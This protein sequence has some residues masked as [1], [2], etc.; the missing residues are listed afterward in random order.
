MLV[1]VCGERS[2]AQT[3]LIEVGREREREGLSGLFG[4]ANGRNIVMQIVQH[5]RSIREQR[6]ST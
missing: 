6:V 1:Y 3:D 5:S 2:G 4:H